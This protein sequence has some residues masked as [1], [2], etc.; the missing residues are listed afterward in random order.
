M[1]SKIEY[2]ARMPASLSPLEVVRRA[3][4]EGVELSAATVYAARR[5][6]VVD[7]VSDDM[8]VESEQ[9]RELLELAAEIGF[10][11]AA[12][13]LASLRNRLIEDSWA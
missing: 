6:G 7:D 11:R 3:K 2:A 10:A 1:I 13:L 12:S 4:A 5:R 8:L 9:E